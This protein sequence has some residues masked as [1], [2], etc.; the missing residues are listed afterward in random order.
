MN[1][2]KQ[3]KLTQNNNQRIVLFQLILLIF[4]GMN[5]MVSC[6]NS[7]KISRI[8]KQQIMGIQLADGQVVTAEPTKVNDRSDEVIRSFVEKW[9]YLSFNWT[10]D[11]LKVEV[12]KAEIPGN[13]YAAT[14]PLTTNKSFRSQY[15]KEFA[16]L[17]DKAT[18]KK[19]SIQSALNI[20]Y[21]SE[22]PT[23]IRHGIWEVTIVSTWV[24]FDASNSRE[25]F[26]IPFNKKLR[27][28]A[29]PIGS[30]PTF[31]A[32]EDITGIQ[33]II[34]QINQYGLQITSIENY[35]PQ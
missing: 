9:S 30:K 22:K 12:D 7:G 17:I 31:Q 11:D 26:T 25:V 10:S 35:D 18:L 23:K 3:T 13:V 21:I 29:V 8:N 6:G 20:S 24:G 4:V 14:F 33:T 19:G 15:T 1:N 32:P 16:A 34:N 5:V 2:I 28:K 27:L